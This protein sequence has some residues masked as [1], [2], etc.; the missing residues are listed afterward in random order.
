MR[1]RPLVSWSVCGCIAFA[2]VT[3]RAQSVDS[4][5]GIAV[6]VDAQTGRYEVQYRP[7]GWTF[8]GEVGRALTDAKTQRGRDK[9]GSYH[10]VAFRWTDGVPF[11][12]AIR[13]YDGSSLVL[14]TITTGAPAPHGLPAFPRFTQFPAGLDH[15]SYKNSVFAPRSFTLEPTSTP[16]LLFDAQANAVVLSPAAHFPVARLLGDGRTEI[17]SALNPE[18][19]PLPTGFEHATV[20]QFGHGIN[21]VWSAWGRT[22]QRI[23]GRPPVP[24]DADIGL[25]Y[26]GYWTDNGAYYYYNYEKTLGYAQ[27]LA[28]LVAHYRERKI[29]IRYLQLDSWWYYK[30]LTDPSGKEGKPKASGLPTAEWNRYGGLMKYEAHPGVFPRGLAAFHDEIG[31]PLI[32]HNRWVD[33]KSPYRGQYQF[34]GLAGVDP[35]WWQ[36]I[37][38]Y[39]SSSGVVCYEQDWLD[40]I[41]TYSPGLRGDEAA[42]LGFFGGMA[43]AAQRDHL[44]VQYCMPEPRHFLQGATYPNVTTIRTSGDRLERKKWDLFLY[45][46]RLALAVGIW[47]WT[48]VFMSGETDNLIIATLSGGMVG[49]GDAIGKEDAENL[50][51]AARPDGVLVKPDAALVPLDE[52]YVAD[53]AGRSEPM[54]A[55][56]YTDHGG[57]RTAYVFAYGRDASAANAGFVPQALGMTGTVVVYDAGARTAQRVAADQRYSFAI[58][59]GGY[60]FLEVAAASSSGL[61]FLGD[62]GKFVADGRK[63]IAAI[64]AENGGLKVTVTFAAGESGVRLFGYSAKV[65]HMAAVSGSVT[66]IDFDPATG[67]YAFSVSPAP[68]VTPESPGND[69]V[70]QA[71]VT[72]VDR[73]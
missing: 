37:M 38:D 36:R 5:A 3:A 32:T 68:A 24:N 30:S 18:M 67:R 20:M 4:P 19:Q 51:R 17:A 65:P 60:A 66:G 6:N 23:V 72:I 12:G 59:G 13:V 34:V 58:K 45:T 2:A 41:D 15:F 29:P 57:R 71:V 44:S 33:P 49:T 39:V 69:P 50:L 63:R 28:N 73:D 27:T 1:L 31:L 47:P 56:T 11:T 52:V 70:Q 25:R 61:C 48:D 43:Q 40:R 64:D 35:A 21:A 53:A 22:L 8:T 10:A 54:V 42:W 46:S 26:L 55:S 62:E 9:L 7:T 14:F 16:W